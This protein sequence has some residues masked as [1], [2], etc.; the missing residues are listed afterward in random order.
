[1]GKGETGRRN[2]KEGNVWVLSP[3]LTV[4]E[5][6]AAEEGQPGP[7]W[8]RALGETCKKQPLTSC[9]PPGPHVSKCCLRRGLHQTS[10]ARA[11]L[12]L[13]QV[14]LRHGLQHTLPEAV[15]D[16]APHQNLILEEAGLLRVKEEVHLAHAAA[17]FV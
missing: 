3:E 12:L 15:L 1:M 11:P 13:Q 2:W 10:P 4:K 9:P 14:S 7:P 6:E 8:K 17:V 16:I 5:G